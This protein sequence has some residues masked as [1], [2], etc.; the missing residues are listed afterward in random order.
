VS[1]YLLYP[2]SELDV[3]SVDWKIPI[4]NVRY[5][6]NVVKVYAIDPAL[7][8][9]KPFAIPLKDWLPGWFDRLC[10]MQK[11]SFC[12]SILFTAVLSYIAVVRLVRRQYSFFRKNIY[13]GVLCLTAIT[14]ILFWL[15]KGPD[16]RFGYGF[17]GIYCSF[18]LALLI[19]FSLKGNKKFIAPVVTLLCYAAPLY[20]ANEFKYMVRDLFKPPI[21]PPQPKEITSVQINHGQVMH[22]V[23][24]DDCWNGP[25]PIATNNEFYYIQPLLRGNTIKEGFKAGVSVH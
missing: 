25:L 2:L 24:H 10:F 16:F 11:V 5:H 6:E 23:T 13:Y 21:A 14:G 7:D 15:N 18:A 20:Y 9:S 3:L 8:L 1:G 17:I 4:E 12:L 22:V 19:S